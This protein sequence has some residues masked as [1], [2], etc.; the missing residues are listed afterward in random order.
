[1]LKFTFFVNS[2]LSIK[3]IQNLT[4]PD[5]IVY[6]MTLMKSGCHH[7]TLM[8]LLNILE[9]EVFLLR[10]SKG[11]FQYYINISHLPPSV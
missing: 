6:T 7:G 3:K 11:I 1:M 10:E 8:H 2:I 4:Y 9:K 5:L